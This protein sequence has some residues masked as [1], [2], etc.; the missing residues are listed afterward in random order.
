MTEPGTIEHQW[1][2]PQGMNCRIRINVTKNTRGYQFE[3]TIEVEG[4]IKPDH[5]ESRAADLLGRTEA[6]ARE[7]IARCEANDAGLA[8]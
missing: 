4:V 6:L 7:D 1:T 5:L 8:S 3:R 2:D